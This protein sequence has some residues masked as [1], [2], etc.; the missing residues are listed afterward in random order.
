M[1]GI[2]WRVAGVGEV[3]VDDVTLQERS[4]VASVKKR[5]RFDNE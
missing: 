1:S 2:G 5:E 4:W 3:Q